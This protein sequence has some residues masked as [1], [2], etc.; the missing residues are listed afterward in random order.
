MA[1]ETFSIGL[2]LPEKQKLWE[3]PFQW[4]A[5]YVA[6]SFFFFFLHAGY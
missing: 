3:Q 5:K 6:F 1:A 2:V 4:Q